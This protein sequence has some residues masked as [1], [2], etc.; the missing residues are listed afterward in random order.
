MIISYFFVIFD[1]RSDCTEKYSK[2]FQ[3]ILDDN[4][5]TNF[6]KTI[7]IFYSVFKNFYKN[8]SYFLSTLIPNVNFKTSKRKILQYHKFLLTKQYVSKIFLFKLF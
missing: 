2:K 3:N 5:K 6:V 4:I 8:A 7:N 1:L